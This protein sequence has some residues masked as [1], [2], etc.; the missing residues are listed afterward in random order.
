MSVALQP[1]MN[2]RLRVNLNG[3]LYGRCPFME[4]FHGIYP[5]IV[6]QFARDIGNQKRSVFWC[7]KVLFLPEAFAL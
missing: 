4:P 3:M 6:Y 2:L 5:S 1:M 7:V